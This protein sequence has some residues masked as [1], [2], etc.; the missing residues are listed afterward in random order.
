MSGGGSGY[1]NR[2]KEIGVYM[3]LKFTCKKCKKRQRLEVGEVLV[4]HRKK[5]DPFVVYGREVRCKFCK[6]TDMEVP[7]AGLIVLLMQKEISPGE[8]GILYVEEKVGIEDKFMPFL[9]VRPYLEKRI[10]EEPEN[11]ELRLR[12]ANFLRKFNE[13]NKAIAEYEE[14]LRL[15]STLFPSLLNLTDIFYH[16]SDEYKEKGALTKAREYFERAVDLYKS[17]NATFATLPDKRE[18]PFWIEDR[19]AILYPKKKFREKRRKKRK[20]YKK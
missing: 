14:S 12:N 2:E 6:S 5:E 8:E 1:S 20:K 16:R 7:Y 13:Y 9:E 4:I 15:D 19:R 3:K 17:G 10:R 11:G 18:I